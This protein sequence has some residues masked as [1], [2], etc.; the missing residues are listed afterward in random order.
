MWVP[1]GPYSVG[2]VDVEWDASPHTGPDDI[3]HAE[4]SQREFQG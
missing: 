3:N 4:A 1:N 2:V